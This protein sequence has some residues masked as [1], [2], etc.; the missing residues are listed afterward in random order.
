MKKF[1]FFFGSLVLLTGMAVLS[2]AGG[3]SPREE[4]DFD[5]LREREWRLTALISPSGSIDL[6]RQKLESEGMGDFYT[7]RF[8]EDRLSGKAAP[9]QYFAPYTPEKN[10]ALSVGPPAGTLMMALKE[11]ELKEHDYFAYLSRVNRWNLKDGKL[12]LYTSGED[13]LE[14]VLIFL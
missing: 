6:S 14:A 5:G 4:G 12:E 1:M 11:P 10:R 9:N 13:G 7:L 2:C 8:D 3:A